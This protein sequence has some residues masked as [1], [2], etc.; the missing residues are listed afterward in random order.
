MRKVNLL[1]IHCAATKPNMDIG[2]DEIDSWHK[3]RGW[4]G[5]GYH[6]VIRRDG[7]IESGRPVE[8][9]G[10]HASG[11]NANSIGICLVGGINHNGKPEF[12]STPP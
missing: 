11:Y 8:Q 7:R 4:S 9:A 10:A 12:Q 1:V 3:A 6:Y 5:I 2:R